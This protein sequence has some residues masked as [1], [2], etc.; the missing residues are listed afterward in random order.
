MQKLEQRICVLGADLT[1][2]SSEVRSRGECAC[3]L[4]RDP[5]NVDPDFGS[6][7]HRDILSLPPTP[8]SLGCRTFY[9]T[10]LDELCSL[11]F[12]QWHSWLPILHRSSVLELIHERTTW[13]STELPVLIKALLVAIGSHCNT[14]EALSAHDTSDWI[15]SLRADVILQSLSDASFQGLQSLLIVSAVSLATD[16]VHEFW[17]AISL[18]KRVGMILGIDDLILN[19]GSNFS[20]STQV[21]SR[22]LR[23]PSTV[24]EMEQ[25][26]RVYWIM[27]AFDSASTLGVSWNTV[28]VQP[29]VLALTIRSV[30]DWASSGLPIP[31]SDS[32]SLA[33][34]ARYI[35]MVTQELWHVHRH[36]QSA[37]LQ[38][39]P[40][41]ANRIY[42]TCQALDARLAQ[43][44][45][46]H[47]GEELA[48]LS[49]EDNQSG[50]SDPIGSQSYSVLTL[51][52]IDMAVL[53]LFQHM[54]TRG[55]TTDDLQYQYA[56]LRCLT[57]CDRMT[58][59]LRRLD[60]ADFSCSSPQLSVCIFV[61]ARFYIVHA[62]STGSQPSPKL[63]FLKYALQCCAQTW[64]L[65]L[66]LS[67][68]VDAA[69]ETG[70]HKGEP[71]PP[72]LWDL[73]YS[74]QDID[75]ALSAWD[76]RNT[77]RS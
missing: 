4:P 29:A 72:E 31:Q 57:A 50:E 56:A 22:M 53:T 54:T 58:K 49:S 45:S 36:H 48:V 8:R 37:I 16:L 12:A 9:A 10:F 42:L 68:I 17:T 75:H 76:L 44:E 35:E 60:E 77:S 7:S 27:E 5:K 6:V 28:I 32:K 33:G 43:W 41:D 18:C 70:S 63:F 64:G 2:L 67:R 51:S 25:H 14:L 21:P 11:W 55:S 73:G 52:M 47:S 26:V 69:S 34:F 19:F 61:A 71:L 13:P 62:K 40:E 66:R 65:A 30:D 24:I 74:W 1:T 20:R 3:T 59:S 46:E 15:A 39:T 23:I 38:Q